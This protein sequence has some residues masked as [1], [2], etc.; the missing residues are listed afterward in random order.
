MA[1]PISLSLETL[2]KELFDDSRLNEIEKCVVAYQMFTFVGNDFYDDNIKNYSG[3]C[4]RKTSE[5]FIKE[6]ASIIEYD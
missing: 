2:S 4:D 3:K 1:V 6:N 5:K